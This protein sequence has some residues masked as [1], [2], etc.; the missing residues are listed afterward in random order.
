M[1]KPQ[2]ENKPHSGEYFGE[3]RDFWW[4][5]D[6]LELMANRLQLSLVKKVLDVGCGIGHWGQIL[7]PVFSE[8]AIV[9]GV[10]RERQWIDQAS[11]KAQSLGLSERFSY[12]EGDATQLP[13]DDGAFDLVTCQTVLIHLRDPKQGLKEMFRVL[14]PGGI[15]LA[16]EPNNFANRAVA[17][18][19][20]EQLS[21]PEVMERLKFEL[22]IE[23]GKQALGLGFNSVGDFVPGLLAQLGAEK[24]KVYLS[25]KAVPFFAPYSTKEQQ[26]NIQMM[27]DWNKRGFIGWDRDELYGYFIAGGGTELEF[28]HF[29]NL[30]KKDNA[31]VLKTIKT[32][33]YHSAGGGI[34]YLIS[35]EKPKNWSGL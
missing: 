22:T 30:I 25:D 28:D 12:L 14:R 15:L 27:E 7:A 29:F 18:N 17:S 13:F 19:L 5:T 11:K 35:A 33:G 10:D 26:V 24:I 6:F 3:Y 2:T 23:R 4:N 21:I 8:D 20:T 16:A 34:F 1:H 32:G 9:I 31:E